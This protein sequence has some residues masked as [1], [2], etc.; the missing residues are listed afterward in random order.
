MPGSSV[1]WRIT[2]F[3]LVNSLIN[4]FFLFLIHRQQHLVAP[5]LSRPVGSGTHPRLALSR[6]QML[7]QLVLS[8][9]ISSDKQ[10]GLTCRLLSESGCSGIH[11]PAEPVR[12][13]AERVLLLVYKVNPRLV[14]K[15][16]PPDDD[17]TRRNLLYRQLFTEFDKIDDGRRRE[18][19]SHQGFTP[20]GTLR[21]GTPPHSPNISILSTSQ[22]DTESD[23]RKF[24]FNNGTNTNSADSTTVNSPRKVASYNY[25]P[26]NKSASASD[27]NEPDPQT[28]NSSKS[29]SES[30]NRCPFC[31][32]PYNDAEQLDKHYWKACPILTKCPQCSQVLEVAAIC[33]HLTGTITFTFFTPFLIWKINLI[34]LFLFINNLWIIEFFLCRRMR[35]KNRLRSMW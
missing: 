1:S 35:C 28:Q 9:G 7:E 18:M 8:Q 24:S 11:H 34:Q 5:A 21:H 33:T 16:L 10:S 14:R 3:S 19:I 17:I 32:W 27:S 26:S 23:N 30:E 15:L 25:S 13:V 20:S 2:K 4:W 31:D 22:H 6:M 29:N 12:K